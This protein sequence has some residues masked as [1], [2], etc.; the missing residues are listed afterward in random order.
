MLDPSSAVVVHVFLDLAL[1]LSRSWFVDG[2]LERHGREAVSESADIIRKGMKGRAAGSR[3]SAAV[4]MLNRAGPVSLHY[5]PINPKAHNGALLLSPLQL[6]AEKG[7][8]HIPI[9]CD[10]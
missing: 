7:A 9:S 2:H 1:L 8:D 10:K 5:F 4:E 6:G 3:A